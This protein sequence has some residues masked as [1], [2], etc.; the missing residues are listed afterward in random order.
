MIPINEKRVSRSDIRSNLDLNMFGC[1]NLYRMNSIIHE[2]GANF[3][4]SGDDQL[5]QEELTYPTTILWPI[6]YSVIKKFRT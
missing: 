1:P 4:S 5:K 3:T 2:R 6:F